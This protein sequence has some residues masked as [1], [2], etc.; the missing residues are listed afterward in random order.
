MWVKGHNVSVEDED[1]QKGLQ[2]ANELES[3]ITYTADE[4]PA[5]DM[6]FMLLV[7]GT[8]NQ[9]QMKQNNKQMR[10]VK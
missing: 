2:L 7:Q 10:K 1:I 4:I 3:G 8:V 9:E 6:E 5:R